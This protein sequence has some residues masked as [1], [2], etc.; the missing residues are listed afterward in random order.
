MTTKKVT[1]KKTSNEFTISENRKKELLI[2]AGIS[3]NGLKKK[4]VDRDGDYPL[5]PGTAGIRILFRAVYRL[6][7]SSSNKKYGYRFPAK[8][9]LT[10]AEEKFIAPPVDK[11]SV[12]VKKVYGKP[13]INKKGITELRRNIREGN[14]LFVSPLD[15]L[16]ESDLPKLSEIK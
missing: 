7:L 11:V 1:T 13:F 2:A 8:D 16:K 4:T 3:G 12:Y 6:L 5:E 14:I 9:F 10:V 15:S